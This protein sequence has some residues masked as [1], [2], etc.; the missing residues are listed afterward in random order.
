[1]SNQSRRQK[2]IQQNSMHTSQSDTYQL[3]AKHTDNNIP[4]TITFNI[5]Y[6]HYIEQPFW[7]TTNIN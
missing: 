5:N 4:T 3:P 6:V 7:P 2:G 1:M